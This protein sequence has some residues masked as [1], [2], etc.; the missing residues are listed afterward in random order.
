MALSVMIPCR[1]VMALDPTKAISQ[2]VH[3]TWGT[4][5]GLPQNTVTRIRET[6]DGYLWIG[7]QAGLARFDGVS[8]TTFDHTNTPSLQRD[9][10]ADLVEDS[11]GTLWIATTNGGVV[12]FHNGLF[13]HVKAVEPRGGLDLA[14]DPDGSVWIGGYGGLK[15]FKN[16]LLI[17]A[18]TTAD[19]LS[20]DPVASLVVDRSGAVWI[21][22]PGGLNRLSNGKMQTY[23]VRDGLPSKEVTQVRLVADGTLVVKTQNAEF[24]R[25]EHDRFVPWHIPGVSGGN[26][27]DVILDRDGNFWLASGTEGLFRVT[28]AQLSRFTTRDGLASDAV[29][30]LYEDHDGNVWVGTQSGGLERFRDGTFTTFAKEEGLSDDQTLSVIED[31]IGDMWITTSNGLDQLHGS[32]IRTYKAVDKLLDTWSLWIDHAS[33]LLIGTSSQ[34][35]IR[36]THGQLAP[37]LSE[38]AGVPAYVMSG[39]VEDSAHQLWVATRGGGLVRC[40]G[41]KITDIYTTKAGLLSN[42]LY[43]LTQGLD[44]TMWIGGDNGLNSIQ[45]GHFTSYPTLKGLPNVWVISL[46]FDSKGILWIGTFGQGL[47][48]LEDGHFTRYTTHQ[49]LQNDTV[50]SIVEDTATNLWIGSDNG[51]SRIT[52]QDL[53]AVATHPLGTFAP[54]IFGTADGMKSS[55]TAGGSQPGAWRS[56]DGRLWFPTVRGVV[57]A[58]PLRLKLSESAPISRIE[59]MNADETRIDVTVPVRLP[60]GT[61]RL[62]IRYTAPNLSSPD[63]TQFRYRLDGFDEQWIPGGVQRVAQYTN[64]SPGHY[65]FHVS[66]SADTGRWGA[67]DS[68]LNFVV[69]PQF[70]Q[71]WWFRLL[72]GFAVISLL[73]GA[74]R[75]RVNF[76]HARAAVLEERQRI[77]RDIHDSLAQ[78]LSAIIFHTQA[79]LYSLTKAS[80]MTSTHM[81]S[82]LDLAVGSLDDARYSV[83][84]LSPAVL[85]PKNLVESISSMAQLLA[86]GRVE[87]L[88]IHSSG[89]EWQLGPAANHHV[90]LI[91]QEAISNAIR[92]GHA[93]N[94]SVHL[95]YFS[96]A[97]HLSVSDN[98]VGFASTP[99]IGQRVRGY[100][101]R[102]MRH[103]ADRLGA[104]L[105]VTST[106]G[107][108]ATISLHMRKL[109]RFKKVWRR[110]IGEAKVRVDG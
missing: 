51:I 60:P 22:S 53:D 27:H 25:W 58:D 89:T 88:E 95:E 81:T 16:G 79:A 80:E 84:D 70:Y 4:V 46:Y 107:S 15:H 29:A 82:V 61:R 47:F 102:N 83:W 28:G 98:G 64:L 38:C 2:Y 36:L 56:H 69:I 63:R 76:L 49:G 75:L 105:K 9:Y 96:E 32:Q 68:T 44:G 35:M 85:D 42:T 41:G 17:K 40:V 62:E 50:N 13:S 31:G 59:Q 106:P 87:A 37:S 78:G 86:R 52:R 97:L 18:Y 34:G 54:L 24:V 101:M 104:E 1:S 43:A 39:I 20:G 33:N 100:G 103:R 10:I 26:V 6:R 77:A 19:G 55:A 12:S 92:H 66:A 90:V 45:N 14:A 67:Q 5:N 74:Y 23:S 94:I 8:F 93:E 73:W 72:C 21:G 30:R 3:S 11:Q 110:L 57:V 48:R 65:T 71:T 7:T 99:D 91:A 108:G 109:G